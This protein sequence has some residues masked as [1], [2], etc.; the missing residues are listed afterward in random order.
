MMKVLHFA[1]ERSGGGAHDKLRKALELLRLQGGQR[2][3]YGEDKGQLARALGDG[4]VQQVDAAFERLSALLGVL[5]RFAV[6]WHACVRES[7]P[8]KAL[9][10]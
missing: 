3:V 7:P 2:G 6:M 10:S 9:G 5:N 1:T 4:G 8:S